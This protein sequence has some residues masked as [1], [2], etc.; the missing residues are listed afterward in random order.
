MGKTKGYKGL[1]QFLNYLKQEIVEGNFG[2]RKM[3]PDFSCTEIFYKFSQPASLKM[4]SYLVLISIVLLSLTAT[5]QTTVVK[6]RQL[7]QNTVVR[8][9]A[10]VSYPYAI[11]QKLLSTGKY[12]LKAIDPANDSTAYIM[13]PM[14]EQQ[15][16]VMVKR[17]PRPPE[18]KFFTDGQKLDLFNV[19]DINGNKVDLKKASGKVIVLNFWF[20][21]CPPCRQEIPELNKIALE[22][23]A[24]PNVVF[25]AVCLDQDYQ[26][27]DFLKTSPFSYHIVDRGQ[28]YAEQ[29]KINLY[30]TNV[31]L[32]KEG[33][34]RF[35]SSGYTLGTPYW[36]KKTIDEAL[37]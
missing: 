10:G 3:S 32:D 9:S 8:D 35:H 12:T 5:A 37:Q 26:I 31:V 4:K 1:L 25:V 16:D 6:R 11:W 33:K 36:I 34:V 30:P 24:N 15:R 17:M 2:G 21:G 23:A 29:F 7:D 22:Y 27:F 14:S 19:R 18:S 20:I 28:Y 13:V